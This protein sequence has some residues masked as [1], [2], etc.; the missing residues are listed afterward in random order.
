MEGACIGR[1]IDQTAYRK[2]ECALVSSFALKPQ[3]ARPMKIRSFRLQ[4]Y[5]CFRDV[6]EFALSDTL[7][8]VIGQ[9]NVG[10]TALLEALSLNFTGK[11]HRSR[12]SKPQPSSILNPLSIGE[13]RFSL[14]G[15]ELI[16]VRVQGE[17]NDPGPCA[18]APQ[19]IS[20]RRQP[21]QAGFQGSHHPGH[22]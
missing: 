4:N 18:D 17:T 9:N 13:I 8:I 1:G 16:L 10:K 15:E 21:W 6:H 5:K 7:N 20:I 12:K 22:I 2:V 14:S 11:P 3:R 19:A